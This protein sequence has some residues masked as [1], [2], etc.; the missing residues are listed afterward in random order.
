MGML[1][2]L[3]E[4]VY[5]PHCLSCGGTVGSGGGL[6]GS[7]WR[8]ATFLAG[9]RCDLCSVPLPGEADETLH[10]DECLSLQ[11]PWSKGRAAIAYS[12]AGRRMVLSLKHADRTDLPGAASQWMI[13]AAQDILEPG[14][15]LAPVP[16]HWIRL[17][18]RRYNQA[19]L[20][21][22]AIAR[23]TGLEHCPDLLKRLRATPTQ[24]GRTRDARFANVAAAIT[25]NPQ[26]RHRLQGRDVL[27]IDDVLTSGATL[28][29]CADVCRN[30]GAADVRV[31]TLARVVK[32]T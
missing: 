29:A 3:V 31:L 30:A 28:A 21:S 22:S 13:N 32:E 7:C 19:A 26:Q 1:D 4:A 18:R 10:C 5:P 9:T 6:C 2:T 14:M 20:L 15:L 16:L 27:L 11:R 24:E 25:I 17:F 23:G 8:E 12:G